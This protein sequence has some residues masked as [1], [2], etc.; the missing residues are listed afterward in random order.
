MTTDHA[1][2]APHPARPIDYAL[3]NVSYIGALTGVGIVLHRQRREIDLSPREA[4]MLALAAF[5]VADVFAHERIATWIRR[6]FDVE[7]ADHRPG[8]PRGQGLRYAIGELMACSRCVGSWSA[9]GL[10]GLRVA[11]PSAS[12]AVT[13]VLAAGGANDFLQAMFR[14][15]KDRADQLEVAA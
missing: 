10:I 13:T 3:I 14:I 7:T 8:H 9:L 11:S 6:P 12:G 4:I 1:D 2:D 5:S 15:L